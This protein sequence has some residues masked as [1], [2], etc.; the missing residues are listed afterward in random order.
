[1]RPL[2]VALLMVVVAP[3]ARAGTVRTWGPASAEAFARGTLQETS[4]DDEG[5][6]TLAA[7]SSTWWGPEGGIVWDVAADGERGAFV[8]LSSPARVLHVLPGKAAETWFD[9]G[10]LVPAVLASSSVP[11]ILPPTQIGDEHYIDGGIVNSIP[12]GEAVNRGG[13]TVYVLQ[14]G[15]AEEQLVAPARPTEVAKIS[16]EI[17]RRHRFSREIASVPPGV[18]V[19]VLPSGGPIA[20]DEKFG[21]YRRMTVTRER[22][23][24]AYRA[25]STYLQELAS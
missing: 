11:G 10:P 13:T 7:T 25:T 12:L 17:A 4:L 6:L 1:M 22:M 24:R 3:A 20:G 14:V 9:K 23:V 5:W 21:S 19:H 2:L 16:F 8:A 15:R 18:V